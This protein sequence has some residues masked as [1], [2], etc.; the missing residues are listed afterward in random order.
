MPL[1]SRGA[2]K[3]SSGVTLLHSRPMSRRRNHALSS[4]VLLFL[5]GVLS[6][7]DAQTEPCPIEN[8]GVNWTASGRITFGDREITLYDPPLEE[9]QGFI[10]CDGALMHQTT[11]TANERFAVTCK[12][13]D[14]SVVVLQVYPGHLL[15][16]AEQ[17]LAAPVEIR[18]HTLGYAVGNSNCTAQ[19]SGNGQ[20]TE[21][22]AS[23]GILQPGAEVTA[24]FHRL[25]HVELSFA[26]DPDLGEGGSCGDWLEPA[27]IVFDL[28]LEAGPDQVSPEG[29]ASCSGT[30]L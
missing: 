18:D 22:D 13:S 23:G 2:R 19:Y 11:S 3:Q 7:C 24:D 1:D 9:D 26:R 4:L 25:R 29:R 16:S 8:S 5:P 17:R 15:P 12:T 21:V 14:G 28:F 6:G 10:V 30:E 20:L 27:T